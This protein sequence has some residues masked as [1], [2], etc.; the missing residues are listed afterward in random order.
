MAENSTLHIGKKIER[1]RTLKGIKQDV[2]AAALGVSQ[3]AISKMELS[4]KISADKLE[5]I[6]K[7]L[8]VTVDNIKDFNENSALTNFQNTF[9]D[10]AIQ[11]NQ[12]N[13]AIQN[14]HFNPIEKMAELYER[15][16]ISE[17]E[18][19]QLKEELKHSG[20]K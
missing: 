8:G 10:N 13:N 20:N 5:K 3:A 11:N 14:N 17:Q 18:K 16:L 2:L 6:A 15:L 9:H 19:T 12:F 1:I 7:A 4:Q